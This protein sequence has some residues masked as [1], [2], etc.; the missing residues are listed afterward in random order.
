MF[1][2]NFKSAV[3]VLFAIVCVASNVFSQPAFRA[4][5]RIAEFKKMKLLEVLDLD[6]KTAEKFLI[7]YTS[8]EKIVRE[9]QEKLEEA[10]LD[11]EYL[12]RK[13]ASKDE[14]SKQSQKVMDLQ[15]DFLNTLLEQ[16]KEIKS[17]LSEEQFAKYLVFENR[18]RERLQQAII[19]RAKGKGWNEKNGKPKSPRKPPVDEEE[20]EI[21]R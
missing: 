17:I 12:L 11:L 3:V 18:F 15:R 4:K 8:I 10:I 14:I 9:K 13:K 5:E 21:F 19:E 6:E 20:I 1:K 16:Q 7:K 2:F